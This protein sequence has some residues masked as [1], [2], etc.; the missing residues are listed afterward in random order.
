MESS[1]NNL[2]CSVII[3]M[4]NAEKFIADTLNS[5]LN[6]SVKDIEILCI[7]DCSSDNTVN[8]VKEFQ[9]K[10]KRI[11]LVEN[12]KNLK[13]SQTRNLG[14]QTAKSDWI[15]LLDSDDMWESNFLEEVIKKKNETN[16]QLISSSCKF[17]TDDGTKLSKQF[18]VKEKIT[19]KDILKQNLILCSSVFIKKELLLKY[20]FKE[21][22]LHED[23]LC[24]LTILK[25]IKFS[26]AVTEPL[27]IYR[28]TKGS[29]SRNKLKS[30]KMS[31]YT[32]RKH[33]LNILKS[34]Y[35]TFCNGING[36]K[37]YRNMSKG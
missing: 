1:K 9:S 2:L 12:E 16:S 31:Y 29:K 5:V 3:P 32:Y 28:L 27:M 17:I 23:Y 7:D 20:P 26:Y 25:E 11:I 21:D 8:I 35:Y 15:A 22:S 34:L 10:D 37:K 19:Y 33:G 36:L 13:V 24:W 18:I 6:Q 14:V 4:Y 30:I